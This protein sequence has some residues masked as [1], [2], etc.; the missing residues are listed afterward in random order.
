MRTLQAG[1]LPLLTEMEVHV[2]TLYLI[3]VLDMQVFNSLLIP[4]VF[5]MIFNLEDVDGKNK[6]WNPKFQEKLDELDAKSSLA[7]VMVA[8]TDILNFVRLIFDFIG[9][10]MVYIGVQEEAFGKA[11]R[12]CCHDSRNSQVILPRWW[13]RTR[14]VV[15]ARD[16]GSSTAHGIRNAVYCN[17]VKSILTLPT[18]QLLLPLFSVSH[19]RSHFNPM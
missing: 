7:G 1:L 10:F 11:M 4:K 15:Y 18:Y 13:A 3:P 14:E 16:Y 9:E 6:L 12:N 17:H 2:G 19:K 8:K 5:K